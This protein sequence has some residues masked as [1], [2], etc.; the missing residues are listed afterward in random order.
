VVTAAY[1]QPGTARAADVI[2]VITRAASPQGVGKVGRLEHVSRSKGYGH[3]AVKNL[4]MKH[5][6]KH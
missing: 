6:K 4:A 3:T 5:M 1:C 2:I